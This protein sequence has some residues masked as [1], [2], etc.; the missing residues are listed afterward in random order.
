[1]F[2]AAHAI[3]QH[4]I[5]A[6]IIGFALYS[7]AVLVEKH[8]HPILDRILDPIFAKFESHFNDSEKNP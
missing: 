5:G 7:A 8:I 4:L 2:E 3:N 1:M 6:L